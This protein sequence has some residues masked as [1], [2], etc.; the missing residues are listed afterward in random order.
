MKQ[1]MILSV[2][3]WRQFSAEEPRFGTRPC[4]WT[5]RGP[6]LGA[7]LP[8]V[9]A[10]CSSLDDD[11]ADQEFPQDGLF[12]ESD[13]STT[14]SLPDEVVLGTD[15]EE[16]RR[17]SA[18]PNDDEIFVVVTFNQDLAG[19]P[20]DE[21]V[22]ID[23][24]TEDD[25]DETT[26]TTPQPR[27][28]VTSI[29]SDPDNQRVFTISLTV[30]DGADGL[31]ALFLKE[32]AL[33]EN[34]DGFF[35][36]LAA[37]LPLGQHRADGM[38]PQALGADPDDYPTGV[39]EAVSV[40]SDG[41]NA[42]QIVF[43]LFFDE[44]YEDLDWGD[45][46]FLDAAGNTLSIAEELVT[47]SIA[48]G[49]LSLDGTEATPLPQF[50]AVTVELDGRGSINV[51]L[52]DERAEED[53]DDDDPA[54]GYGQ[55]T[56]IYGN[57]TLFSDLTQEELDRYQLADPYYFDIVSPASLTVDETGREVTLVFSTPV[58]AGMV[59][60]DDFSLFDGDRELTITSLTGLTDTGDEE[61]EEEEL[62]GNLSYT[63]FVLHISESLK[64]DSEISLSYEGDMDNLTYTTRP[65]GGLQAT[66]TYVTSFTRDQAERALGDR[67]TLD[68][69]QPGADASLAFTA[70]GAMLMFAEGSGGGG[71]V[72]LVTT[73]TSED[74]ETEAV[75]TQTLHHGSVGGAG[76]GTD[77]VLTGGAGSDILFADGSGGGGGGASTTSTD[78]DLSAGTP[79]EGGTVGD[80]DDVLQGGG[81]V[82][83]LIGDG[84]AGSSGEGADGGAGGFGGGGGGEA[85]LRY[86]PDPDDEAET[87]ALDGGTGGE[88]GFGGGTG[89]GWQTAIDAE[90]DSDGMVTPATEAMVVFALTPTYGHHATTSMPERI[91][92]GAGVSP[93]GA[94][95]DDPNGG[96]VPNDEGDAG[97][98]GALN[99]A[100]DQASF[101]AFLDQ[102]DLD[103]N[104]DDERLWDDSAMQA[105]GQGRDVLDGGAG[106]DVL[107][108][109]GGADLFVLD[110][111]TMEDGE[112][113]RILDWGRGNDL[114]HLKDRDGETI[115]F[116]F[117][118]TTRFDITRE[119]GSDRF[120]SY[121]SIGIKEL[122]EG[123]NPEKN[124]SLRLYSLH[125]AATLTEDDF[126]DAAFYTPS[127]FQPVSGTSRLVFYDGSGSGGRAQVS[128]TRAG[129]GGNGGGGG[130][131]GEGDDSDPD[132]QQAS[133]SSDI[134]F[135]DGSGGGGGGGD[136]AA[137]YGRGGTGGSGDDVLNGKGGNDILFGD[138]YGGGS[139]TSSGSGL[140]GFGG[141][142]RGQPLT[143]T[144]QS[145]FL[146]R[147]SGLVPS[148]PGE[149]GDEAV[150]AFTLTD[151]LAGTLDDAFEDLGA[152]FEDMLER[153][154]F[155]GIDEKSRGDDARVWG[156]ADG[157]GAQA[158]GDG[159]DVLQG[160]AGSD[161]LIGL[162]G[163]DV[164]VLDLEE[165]QDGDIDR[166]LDWGLGTDYLE[167]RDFNGNL[168]NAPLT[169]NVQP[170]SEA[171]DEDE[172]VWT[173]HQLEDGVLSIT[174]TEGAD[175]F[176]NYR[177][178]TFRVAPA[179]DS[180]GVEEKIVQTRFY[181]FH[182]DAM[183]APTALTNEDFHAPVLYSSGGVLA[184]LDRSGG[185]GGASLDSNRVG[186]DGGDGQGEDD[187]Y[188]SASEGSDIVFADGSGG[189]G[190]GI[191]D[192]SRSSTRAGTGGEAGNG[193]DI[194]RTGAGDDIIFA[195][196]FDGAAGNRED[197]GAGGFGFA[198]GGA[199]G[200]QDDDD[201]T[202]GENGEDGWGHDR[203]SGNGA[204][205]AGTTLSTGAG[206]DGTNGAADSNILFPLLG[207]LSRAD[208]E[209]LYEAIDNDDSTDRTRG[210][211]GR[212]TSSRLESLAGE[213]WDRLD[214]GPGNDILI[215]GN[216]VDVVTLDMREMG[217]GE[218]DRVFDFE[219]SWTD[220]SDE[221]DVT[222]D[223][224]FVIASD[225]RRNLDL[226]DVGEGLTRRESVGRDLFGSYLE[227]TLT[228]DVKTVFVRLYTP[229]FTSASGRELERDSFLTQDY[230]S[231]GVILFGDQSG[232]GGGYDDRDVDEAEGGD[233]GH[234]GSGHD[235]LQGTAGSDILFGDGSGGGGGSSEN[236]DDGTPGLAG[237]GDDRLFGGAGDDILFGDGLDGLS[238]GVG[239]F[240]G[241][242]NGV[243]NTTTTL[244][245][246]REGGFQAAQAAAAN[247]E[248][249]AGDAPGAGSHG[250]DFAVTL[251]LDYLDYLSLIED[252]DLDGTL[253]FE[254]YGTSFWRTRA[255]HGTGNDQLDGE[256]GDDVL[257]GLGGED[258][259]V[260]DLSKM[261]HNETDRILD[262]EPTRINDDDEEVRVDRLKLVDSSGEAVGAPFGDSAFTL[263]GSREG[264]DPWGA[265]LELAITEEQA[266]SD[267]AK[268]V[269][270]RF[271]NNHAPATDDI[272]PITDADFTI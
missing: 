166:V 159:R 108:G 244:A 75:T 37:D 231:G 94:T 193:H 196:G 78:D 271:Y 201:N 144:A 28:R 154:D 236:G 91:E 183:I 9:L 152:F 45:L 57:A 269:Y 103:G 56:D 12:V 124:V 172:D 14:Y 181:R 96:V 162:G 169:S 214:A 24:E 33:V 202:E 39:T 19:L 225:G 176:G 46:V 272:E 21:I 238:A 252:I 195:D 105:P 254:L 126:T 228:D 234:G 6:L 265:F 109:G 255:S 26:D 139:T 192:D 97:A 262:W 222:G 121:L 113:D 261:A 179:A 263:D 68:L 227:Q 17:T 128:S 259:F 70:G 198:G 178:L 209:E 229:G 163:S 2:A 119:T 158:R 106:N 148:T 145:E 211:D 218:I 66:E 112:I 130:D 11:F 87:I 72:Q 7:P 243:E 212:I 258:V 200:V 141:G 122:A 132:G 240:G 246:E 104:D 95:E 48:D 63:S 3:L 175:L 160:G 237:A 67:I 189:G 241:G 23:D 210:D 270:V 4:P 251:D 221:D 250:G 89:A 138:G 123:M 143:G 149:A 86:G 50:V 38:G 65:S 242:A 35:Y 180:T 247:G 15:S 51:R 115:A 61:L 194:I 156:D 207:S 206:D 233:G 190:G 248:T 34:S 125:N 213:G 150:H 116:P 260:L 177:A 5:I 43:S 257:I 41:P 224:L 100:L 88:G 120:G 10:A 74:S 245:E 107:L 25:E 85:Y 80:G 64:A 167:I 187:V 102:L 84:F 142:G 99:L 226:D 60:A 62:E 47:T 155:D 1:K 186:G 199:A 40:S 191:H 185:G 111:R 173:M 204:A 249:T 98:P 20:L 69:V 81:G 82:D 161:F 208:F 135:G 83:I 174:Q 117:L 203:F 77:S 90:T 13:G 114:L 235:R 129:S 79:G 18:S 53:D 147:L 49:V 182:V 44:D 29:Q 151:A 30:D 168:L 16:A 55:I 36:R 219:E 110:L 215:T 188:E 232:G 137:T 32:G 268:T 146:E 136:R 256:A 27:G 157:M 153:I 239:G 220:L 118:R 58:T 73:E 205:A 76:R 217:H 71:G 266:N 164:F 8:L 31:L 171:E 131:D 93:D 253:D 127:L 101:E 267:S 59:E 92:A 22:L 134:L 54:T 184:L 197:G 165:S 264:T 216:G 140:G 42:R 170:D 230:T 223:L 52:S 133:D